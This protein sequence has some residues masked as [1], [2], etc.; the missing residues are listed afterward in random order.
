MT[1]VIT[2]LEIQKRDRGRVNVF[3]DD[4]FAFSLSLIEAAKLRKGQTLT[5][6]EI[7]VLRGED[8]LS[9]GVDSAVRFLAHRPRSIQEVRR[10]L[11]RK[12]LPPTVLEAVIERLVAMGYLDDIAFA[13]FGLKTARSRPRA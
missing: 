10:N 1:H 6:A 2:A 12:G 9:K 13:R 8:A 11:A 7:S 3:L 4:E 5:E